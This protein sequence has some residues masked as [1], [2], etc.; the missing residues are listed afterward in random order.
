MLQYGPILALYW[1]QRKQIQ[2]SE[3]FTQ[4]LNLDINYSCRFVQYPHYPIAF[5]LP[6]LS[7]VAHN[8]HGKSINL[9]A[10]RKTHGKQNNL[11]AHR[12]DSRQKE[13]PHGKNKKTQSKKKTSRQKQKDSQ[14]NFFDTERTFLFYFFCREVVVILF[15][16]TLFFLP[17]GYSFCRE[18][19]LFAVR[20]ILLLWQLW[21]T[22]YLWNSVPEDSWFFN[23]WVFLRTSTNFAHLTSFQATELMELARSENAGHFCMSDNWKQSFQNAAF[24]NCCSSVVHGEDNLIP[25]LHVFKDFQ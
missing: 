9:T 5:C 10:K 18:V 25:T 2:E 16:V 21:A 15:V 4:E 8:C 19:F 11:M 12:K 20:L 1:T 22:V 23:M 7:T 14:Q 13:K 3:N 6:H 17:W 24:C